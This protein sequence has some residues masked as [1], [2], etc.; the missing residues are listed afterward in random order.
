MSERLAS[1]D[2]VV[3]LEMDPGGPKNEAISAVTVEARAHA[4][5]PRHLTPFVRS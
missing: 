4:S 5:E 3:E 1:H 2:G